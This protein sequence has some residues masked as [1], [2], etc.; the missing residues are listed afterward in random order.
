MNGQRGNRSAIM[1]DRLRNLPDFNLSR[2][3]SINNN[4][5]G[6]VGYLLAFFLS[7]FPPFSDFFIN[8]NCLV[9]NTAEGTEDDEEGEKRRK[10]KEMSTLPDG[11]SVVWRRGVDGEE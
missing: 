8:A 10:K 3:V 9:L 6:Q 7:F 5:S 4:D 11:G 2:F 1:S